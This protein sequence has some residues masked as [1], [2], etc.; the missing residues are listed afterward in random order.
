[1]EYRY[2]NPY[3]RFAQNKVLHRQAVAAEHLTKGYDGPAV[4]KDFTA[5]V[6]AG[7]KIAIIG[8]NGVGKTTLLRLLAGDLVADSGSLKWSDNADMGYMA[9]DVSDQFQSDEILFDWMG[10]YRQNGDEDNHGDI[11]TRQELLLVVHEYH[12]GVLS[13]AR[14]ECVCAIQGVQQRQPHRVELHNVHHRHPQPTPSV[15]R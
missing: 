10:G 9:Q 5:M 15:V 11:Q 7:E 6:E 3:I 1:M 13:H 8:A 2:Q 14:C 4:I 12:E